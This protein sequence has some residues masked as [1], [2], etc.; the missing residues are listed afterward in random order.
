MALESQH[1]RSMDNDAIIPEP[2]GI[3]CYM[4]FI[5]CSMEKLELLFLFS[6]LN[7]LKSMENNKLGI[8]SA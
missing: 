8:E 7:I 5:I 1:D 3:M 4:K 6:Q 2:M